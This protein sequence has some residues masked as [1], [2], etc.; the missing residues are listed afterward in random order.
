MRAVKSVL[1]SAGA[2]KLK[3]PNEIEEEIVLRAI[4]DTNLPKFLSDDA[5]L[6]NDILTDLF[7]GIFLKPLNYEVFEK[8]LLHN[9]ERMKLECNDV[10]REKIMQVL[11]H[12]LNNL[13]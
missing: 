5:R 3:Y 1:D 11:L 7:P 12:S 13:I 10:F 2:L 8:A 4:K 6:F 9:F